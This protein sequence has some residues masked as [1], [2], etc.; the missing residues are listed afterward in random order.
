MD[1]RYATVS[2]HIDFQ[3]ITTLFLNGVPKIIETNAKGGRTYLN[4]LALFRIQR[5][6]RGE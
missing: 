5:I 6:E 3:T 2:C 4:F 1:Q